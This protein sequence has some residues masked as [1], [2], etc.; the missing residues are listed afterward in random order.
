V[1]KKIP[2]VRL[3]SASFVARRTGF[4]E[5]TIRRLAD[6]GVVA[7]ERDSG[8]T[9]LFRQAAIDQLVKRATWATTQRQRGERPRAS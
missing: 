6:E 1:Q 5:S 3:F 7:C 9:R 4:A 2:P 8:N